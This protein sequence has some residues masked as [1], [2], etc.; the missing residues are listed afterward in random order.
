[1]ELTLEQ[2][3]ER[4][5]QAQRWLDNPV[6]DETFVAY[7]AK[8]VDAWKRSTD[9]DERESLW[10]RVGVVSRVREGVTGDLMGHVAD[11]K[12]ADHEIEKQRIGRG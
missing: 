5:E 10:H 4:G 3:R 7:E 1:M 12:V 8:C 6:L 9:A 11:G 2:R